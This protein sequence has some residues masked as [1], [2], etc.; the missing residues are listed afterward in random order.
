MA[1]CRNDF[2]DFTTVFNVF[3]QSGNCGKQSRSIDAKR[4]GDS[5]VFFD[6][7]FARNHVADASSGQTVKF[8]ERPDDRHFFVFD[9]RNKFRTHPVFDKISIRFVNHDPDVIADFVNKFFNLS[10]I[11][12]CTG[13]V[14]GVAQPNQLGFFG[15][16]SF[17]RIKIV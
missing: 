4:L 5:V 12:D 17:H 14:V 11:V 8:R 9:P 13:R 16:R 2:L 7:F 1:F 10:R 3:R 15:N 6:C